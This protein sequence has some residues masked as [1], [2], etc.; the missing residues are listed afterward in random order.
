MEIF[1]EERQLSLS[2]YIHGLDYFKQNNLS[3]M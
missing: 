1:R 3:M 2:Y